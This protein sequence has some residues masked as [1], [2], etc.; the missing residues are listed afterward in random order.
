MGHPHILINN[1]GTNLRKDL[2]NFT[3]EEFRGVVDSSLISTFIMSRAFVPGMK[4]RGYGR[5]I[6]LA[7][8]MG[9]I[10]LPGR[11]PYSS[12]KAALLGLTKSLAL[13]L[14]LADLHHS[15]VPHC[16]QL[17]CLERLDSPG[18]IDSHECH[19]R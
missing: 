13:E 15:N 7:S 16:G 6:N 18:R 4:G 1:A 10:S 5:V 14:A 9:H 8:I 12:A 17:D 3:R 11:T 2:V 19:A